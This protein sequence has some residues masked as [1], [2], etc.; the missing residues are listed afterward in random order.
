MY[1]FDRLHSN[2]RD[3]VGEGTFC[4]LLLIIFMFLMPQHT[5]NIVFFSRVSIS[6]RLF[7]VSMHISSY[8]IHIKALTNL[9]VVE[10]FCF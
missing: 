2:A 7:Y 1:N 6:E 10:F 5:T 9:F 4:D 3:Y 8:H